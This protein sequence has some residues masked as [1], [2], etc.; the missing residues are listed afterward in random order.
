MTLQIELSPDLE[1]KL[2]ERAAAV[3]KDVTTFAREALEETVS[4]HADTGGSRPRRST[5]RRVEE[6]LA[7]AASHRPLGH[8]VDDS[9][10]SIYEGRGE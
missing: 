4:L 3:G 6:F 8:I 2:R 10:E 9:R 7:W 1:A 5:K